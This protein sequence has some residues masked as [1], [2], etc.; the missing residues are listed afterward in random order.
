MFRRVSVSVYIK[1]T[2][3]TLFTLKLPYVMHIFAKCMRHTA[4]ELNFDNVYSLCMTEKKEKILFK[5][6]PTITVM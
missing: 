6:K 3:H 1:G 4:S 5:K 2:T